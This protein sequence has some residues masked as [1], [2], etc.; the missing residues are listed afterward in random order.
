MAKRGSALAAL[1]AQRSGARQPSFAA[2]DSHTLNDAYMERFEEGLAAVHGYQRQP[3]SAQPRCWLHW[4][5]R[6]S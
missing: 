2:A 6:S 4:G 1:K 5:L 3:R